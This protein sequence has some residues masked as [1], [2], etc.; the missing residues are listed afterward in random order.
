MHLKRCGSILWKINFW[1]FVMNEELLYFFAKACIDRLSDEKTPFF[2]PPGPDFLPL[3]W[4][5]SVTHKMWRWGVK[6][7]LILP[8]DPPE[9]RAHS[10]TQWRPLRR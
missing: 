1:E 2:S 3:G 5:A 6:P 4:G 7:S 8:R 10:M 9:L